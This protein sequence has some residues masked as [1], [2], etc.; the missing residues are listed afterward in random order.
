MTPVELVHRLQ[1]PA[2][3][4]LLDVREVWEHALAALPGSRLIPLGEL[5]GRAGELDDWRE[6]EVV[7]YCHH[8][9]RS[10]RA[11][12][13]LRGLGFARLHNLSGGIDRWSEEADPKVPRY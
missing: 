8:G 12:A 3:P 7:V 5:S 10:A 2:A 13:F 6:A 9:V 1:G 4:H 11:I